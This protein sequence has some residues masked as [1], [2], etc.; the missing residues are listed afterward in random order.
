MLKHATRIPQPEEWN[1]KSPSV[2]GDQ[3]AAYDDMRHRCPIAHSDY[4]HWSVFRHAD[5]LR[6]LHQPRTFSNE[7]STH[8]SVPNGMDPPA[9]TAYRR[10]IE[11]YF[12]QARI[13]AFEPLC[14]T[15]AAT[16]VEKLP[17]DH[18]VE[19]MSEL[20]QTFALEAQSAFLGWPAHLHEP[21]RQWTIKNR[22]ATLARDPVASAA[23]ALEFDGHIR[24]ILA[25][26]RR[27]PHLSGDVTSQLLRER[28]G[29]RLLTD[30]EI[31]SILR[32]WTVGEL[33]TISASV[34]IVLYYLAEH[35]PV[36]EQLR[37]TPELLPA[38]IDEILRIHP[39]LI[40][41][42]RKA[43]RPVNVG[44][45]SIA[46]GERLTLMWASANRDESVFGDPDELRLDRNPG[47]NLLYGA[48][49][50]VCPGAPLARLELRVLLEELLHR[51]SRISPLPNKSPLNA[52]YPAG[53]YSEAW[54]ILAVNRTNPF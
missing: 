23:V 15:L 24:E 20:A 18:A 54:V 37:R 28:A 36:Q 45:A 32:N 40:A 5:V 7:V 48:G 1:P 10:I 3:I 52:T 16:L 26:R 6:V 29:E 50:H 31:V 12:S 53:G 8:L 38:A 2:L 39:P 14:R 43:T 19:I 46:S 33:A 41:S 21:L 27:A 35:A 30:E 51:T 25:A 11:R 34:G 13:D 17:S 9:H 47:D 42:R 44:G 22:E 4:L 49:I